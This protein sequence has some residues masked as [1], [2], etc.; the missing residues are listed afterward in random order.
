MPSIC[1]KYEILKEIN[2]NSGIKTYLTRIEPIVK[3]II[4]KDI[5]EYVIIKEKIEKIK[6]IIKIYEIIEEKDKLY[7]VMDNNNKLADQ[8]DELMMSDELDF[9]KEAILKGH[10]NPITKEEIIDLFKMENSICKISFEKL[11]DNE[12]KIGKGTGFFCEIDDF[13]IKHA[14]FTNNHVLDEYNIKKGN[15][16][17]IEYYKKS[18]LVKKKIKIDGKRRVFTNK[19]LDYTCIE[20]FESDDIKNYFKIDPILFNDIN[21]IKNSDIFILQYP[22]GNGLSFSCG[23]ILT[24]KDNTINHSASTEEGSS[25]SP[26]I[27]RHKVNCIIGLHF[28]GVKKDK[29]IFN[30]ATIF[31]SIL[32]DINK[33]NEIN[34]IYI[35]KD[36][37]KEIQLIHDYKEDISEYDKTFKQLYSKAKEINKQFFEKNIELFLS[38][39]KIQFSYKYKVDEIED[40]KIKFKLKSNL[41]NMSFM[42]YNC[43]SLKSIDFSSFNAINII[44]MHSLFSGC[45]SLVSI[46][47]S[48]FDTSNATDMSEMFRGC[49]SLKSIDLS[50]FNTSNATDMSEMFRG[51]SS[52]KSIDLSSFNTTKVNDMSNMFYYCRSLESVD[53]SSFNTGKLKKN[54]LMFSNCFS[55]K[56]NNIKFNKEDKKLLNAVMTRK[57]DFDMKI[58]ILGKFDVGKTSI[59]SR[60]CKNSFEDDTEHTIAG[61]YFTQNLELNNEHAKIKL[62]IWDTNGWGWGG[63]IDCTMT[64]GRIVKI[65][66]ELYY[67]DAH[68]IILVYDVTQEDSFENLDFWITEVNNKVE[69]AILCLAGNKNDVEEKDKKVPT[70]KG[71]AFA[72]KNNMIFYE[73]SAKTG[74]GIKELFQE[75]A[76][77]SLE[78]FY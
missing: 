42:F 77:K 11:I 8:F 60:F 21:Y 28:A 41:S 76:S 6:N 22:G 78:L 62:H 47:L 17:N 61:R 54:D 63:R 64:C 5:N 39:K 33:P 74:S 38:Q 59:L 14:L 26:I 65:C 3:E 70:S 34:C 13:P 56:D 16:I 35:A 36:E 37:E 75:I 24:L 29:N 69:N 72:E 32:E 45:E 58:V 71:K 27:R 15:I 57:N 31:N 40:I 4:P 12:V 49:Y 52:L 51:C 1:N 67:R 18:S 55:L 19:K 44:N 46:N 7:I 66:L 30:V 2:T 53:L 43:Y 9:K 23:K 73:I 10:G 20:I 48:S 25:G 50:S 68:A